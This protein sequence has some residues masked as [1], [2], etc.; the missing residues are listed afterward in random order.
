MVQNEAAT[1][2]YICSEC[3][4]RRA[5]QARHFVHE[6]CNGTRDTAATAAVPAPAG[7]KDVAQNS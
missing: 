2:V 5:E 7:V 3:P 6:L 4:S 1:G